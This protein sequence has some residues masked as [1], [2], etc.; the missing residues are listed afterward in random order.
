M[1][2]P[3]FRAPNEQ[4]S[5]GLSWQTVPRLLSKNVGGACTESVRNSCEMF[6]GPLLWIVN[7]YPALEPGLTADG[8]SATFWNA[9]PGCAAVTAAGPMSITASMAPVTTATARRRW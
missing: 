1:S 4:N 7:E 5:T 2:A 3:A 6:D 8:R 9:Q